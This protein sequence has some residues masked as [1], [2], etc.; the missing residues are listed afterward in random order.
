MAARQDAFLGRV[1][2]RGGGSPPSGPCRRDPWQ[3]ARRPRHPGFPGWAGP[4]GPAAA[5]WFRALQD[6]EERVGVDEPRRV[7]V[8]AEDDLV[9]PRLEPVRRKE[10]GESG[11][12]QI[13][14]APW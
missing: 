5:A 11:R 3:S 14:R 7:L 6:R 4:A 13:G 9:L 2:R 12:G 10:E 1:L 8:T